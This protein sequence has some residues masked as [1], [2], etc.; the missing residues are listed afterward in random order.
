MKDIGRKKTAVFL[1]IQ[2]EKKTLHPLATIFIKQCYETLIDVA[3]ESGGKL[4]YRT[5]FILDEFANMPPLKDVTT[6]VT[7]ARSRLIR[8]NF[9]IQNYAQLTQVY[10]KENAET[11]KGNCNI[12]YLISNELSALEEISKMCGEVKSKEKDKTASTPLVTVSDLQRL[13]QFE[14]I[15]LRLRMMPFKTK[16]TPDFKMDWG[17]KYPKAEFPTRERV[18]LDLFDVREFVKEKKKEKM[19][20]MFGGEESGS[21]FGGSTPSSFGGGMG[22]NPFMFDNPFAPSPSQKTSF[23]VDELVK[24]IDEKI[25]ELEKEE[26]DSKGNSANDLLGS[27]NTSNLEGM[28]KFKIP[29]SNNDNLV[30]IDN[31]ISNINDKEKEKNN[32]SSSV[33]EDDDAF[34]DDFFSDN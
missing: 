32:V 31:I 20:S 10:G 5:N 14:M 4:P 22:G 24:K 25:A 28:D 15:T 9:I 18:P 16:L 7:A 6:M 33:E 26:N 12:M 34:F 21:L 13:S 8:F 1:V 17:R 3:Q 27:N 19:K 30:N 11:I 2:D 29:T 23:N